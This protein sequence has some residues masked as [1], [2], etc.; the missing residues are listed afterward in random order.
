MSFKTTNHL[1]FEKKKP[2]D[3]DRLAE[4]NPYLAA[5]SFSFLNN[6]TFIEYINETLNMYSN[7]F[8]SPEDKFKFFE[9]VIVKSKKRPYKY[10][11]RAQKDRKIES[12]PTPEFY[13]TRELAFLKEQLK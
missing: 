8:A 4:F 5:R 9:N 3:I 2:L 10:I 7:L 11:K 12:E 1:L 6:G 13:S